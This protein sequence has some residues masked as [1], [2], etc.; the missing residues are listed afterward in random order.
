V[1]GMKNK[2]KTRSLVMEKWGSCGLQLA[3]AVGL[4]NRGSNG[5][6][7]GLTVPPGGV[8]RS[9]REINVWVGEQLF[10]RRG[11]DGRII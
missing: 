10:P 7:E 11:S 3:R 8:A 6:P 9:P 2:K 1:R 5:S 4:P